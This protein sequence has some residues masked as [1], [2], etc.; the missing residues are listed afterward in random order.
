MANKE[1]LVLLKQGVETWNQ[2]RE[3]HPEIKP[4][5][6]IADLRGLYL[7]GVNLSKVNLSQTNL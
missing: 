5:L 2:W 1:H 6:R 3:T 7:K 4:D